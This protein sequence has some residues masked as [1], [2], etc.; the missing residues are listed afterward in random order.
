MKQ[1]TGWQGKTESAAEGIV[2]KLLKLHRVCVRRSV[3]SSAWA[4]PQRI[5]IG[6]SLETQGVDRE[7][8]TLE[9]V[10]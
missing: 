4:R 9:S 1:K 8:L 3:T 7:V 6:M 2:C 5:R 10:G